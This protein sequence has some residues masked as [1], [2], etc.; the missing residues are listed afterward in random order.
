MNEL[1]RYG[2]FPKGWYF[3]E[4]SK[5]LFLSTDLVTIEVALT[6]QQIQNIKEKFEHA[7]K[8]FGREW[9]DGMLCIPAKERES[10]RDANTKAG[11][12]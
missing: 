12:G 8:F 11:E 5:A 4:E 6:P 9:R 3:D 10:L 2:V 7:R 1:E